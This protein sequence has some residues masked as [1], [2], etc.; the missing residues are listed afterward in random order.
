MGLNFS[1]TFDTVSHSILPD[2]MS[3]NTVGDQLADGCFSKCHSEWGYNRLTVNHRRG[4]PGII[5]RA[6]ALCHIV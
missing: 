6:S 2:K 5:F 1:K 4:S 3:S